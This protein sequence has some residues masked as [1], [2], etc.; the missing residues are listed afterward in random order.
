[1]HAEALNT[2]GSG[3]EDEPPRAAEAFIIRL[4]AEISDVEAA[5]AVH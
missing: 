4:A 2:D 5:K 1:M 3:F